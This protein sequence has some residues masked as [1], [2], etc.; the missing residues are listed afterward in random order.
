MNKTVFC[1][2]IVVFRRKT[3]KT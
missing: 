2:N 3:L 1:M